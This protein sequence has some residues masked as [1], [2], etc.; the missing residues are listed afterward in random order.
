MDK[1]GG[2]IALVTGGSADMGISTAKEFLDE[3]AFAVIADRRKR[4][5]NAA[6]QTVRADDIAMYAD[7]G[8]L[9]DLERFYV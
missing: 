9:H 1:L 3:N 7:G 4:E 5:L 8:R 2:K 6:A